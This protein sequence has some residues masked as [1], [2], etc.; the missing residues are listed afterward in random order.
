MLALIAFQPLAVT[1]GKSRVRD[2][3][4]VHNYLIQTLNCQHTEGNPAV[5]RRSCTTCMNAP[6]Q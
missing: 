4:E 2:H 5:Y 1:L 3:M 6:S